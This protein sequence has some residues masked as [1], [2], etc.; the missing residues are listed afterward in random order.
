MPKFKVAKLENGW[1]LQNCWVADLRSWIKVPSF[2]F[3]M[4]QTNFWPFLSYQCFSL[5]SVFVWAK[6]FNSRYFCT[7]EI[8]GFLIHLMDLDFGTHCGT[9]LSVISCVDFCVIFVWLFEVIYVATF[10][11]TLDIFQTY[12]NLSSFRIRVCS[13][14]LVLVFWNSKYVPR[15]GVSPSLVSRW[16]E[17]YSFWGTWG[18]YI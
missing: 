16:H 8:I 5:M 11:N 13:F 17:V 6:L 1:K 2:L 10:L 4:H 12:F 18:P 9:I 14:N 3:E 7:N 15:L